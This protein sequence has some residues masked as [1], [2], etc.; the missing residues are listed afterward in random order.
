MVDH[1]KRV[2]SAFAGLLVCFLWVIPLMWVLVSQVEKMPASVVQPSPAQTPM[3]AYRPPPPEEIGES[4]F[5]MC[6]ACH[7]INRRWI[8][9]P[10]RYLT[11]VGNE[12]WF[13]QWVT[14]IE[15]GKRRLTYD[16]PASCQ[17]FPYVTQEE[18]DAIWAYLREST[19]ADD[20]Y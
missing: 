13:F 6:A 9:P 14:G 16:A 17:V 5:Q 7:A 19:V 15:R 3:Q 18:T 1:E 12:T 4:L 20:F 2:A 8:G 10:L 11:E